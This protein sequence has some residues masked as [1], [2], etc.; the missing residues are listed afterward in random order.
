VITSFYD[1]NPAD[2]VTAWA[3]TQRFHGANSG[4]AASPDKISFNVSNPPKYRLLWTTIPCRD[5][6]RPL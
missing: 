5:A 4:S 3:T 1:I 2:V 6:G